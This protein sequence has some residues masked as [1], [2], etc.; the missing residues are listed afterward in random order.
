MKNLIKKIIYQIFFFSFLIIITE[1]I[2]GYWFKS[3]G[4]GSTIRN[5]RL[6]NQLYEVKY[7]GIKYEFRY[8]KNFYG[9]RGEEVDPEKIKIFFLGASQGNEKWKPENLT[10]VG[11]LN[12]YLKEDNLDSKKIYNASQDGFSTFGILNYLLK[13][14]PKIKNYNPNKM[15][16]HIG[17]ADALLC[18]DYV[19]NKK[20]VGQF[21]S[22][23]VWDQLEEQNQ[24]KKIKDYI[25]NT[26][27]FVGKIKT[28]QL[29]YFS[30]EKQKVERLSHD[31]NLINKQKYINLFEAEKV[32][33]IK[34]M[35]KKYFPCKKRFNNNL[36]DIL[37]FAKKNKIKI[38]LVNSINYK[39]LNDD[40]LYYTNLMISDFA[41]KNSIQFVDISKITNIDSNDFYDDQHTTPAGSE[42]IAKF[43]Y[44]EVLKFLNK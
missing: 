18:N 33:S 16:L 40:W 14:Y 7:N 37:R 43:I 3:D 31:E 8:K 22:N 35:E 12:Q 36:N 2:F 34:K 6:K 23:L 27:F 41:N 4:F 39:G 17:I 44:P 1:V 30:H 24:T 10:I 5:G 11:R 38:L 32:H 42:K 9:F 19:N 13:F 20:N 25:K 21:E 26:S 15:I 28:I 29:K